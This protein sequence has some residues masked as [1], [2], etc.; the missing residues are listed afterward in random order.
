MSTT[1]CAYPWDLLDDPG[2]TARVTA[3]GADGVVIAAAYHSVR[4]ATPLHP[5]RAVVHATRAAY[6]L[7]LAEEVW[8]SSALR[9]ST[10]TPWAGDE[11]FPR[12]A[13]VARAA[14]LR[15][16]AWL[17]LTHSSHLGSRHPHLTV[18]NAF[19]E[20]YPYALCPSAPEVRDYAR[21]LVEGV[22]RTGNLDGLMIE[23][24]GPLGIGHLGHHE[25]TQGADWTPVAER[26]LSVCF[27]DACEAMLGRET[28]ADR[29]RAE[30]RA[31]VAA[32]LAGHHGTMEDH[33]TGAAAVLA[34]RAAA[35]HDLVSRIRE[36]A[37]PVPRV[38]V[39]GRPDPWATGPFAAVGDDA[40]AFD[41]VVVPGG[42]LTD[43][44]TTAESLRA[45]FPGARLGGYLMALPPATAASVVEQWP[46]V[47]AEL[48]DAYLYHLGLLSAARLEAVGTAVARARELRARMP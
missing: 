4:A 16:E 3:A 14:G 42:L 48:D 35:R 13:G 44:G 40:T 31:G 19:H 47:L 15:V 43:G 41:G 38:V 37:A 46:P 10:A 20:H 33:L 18:R 1:F 6:Y 32:E 7:P 24:C 21:R 30:V 36:A 28:D 22:V 27:C 23:A 17:V 5:R 26:L 39:H 11:A 2:A 9:P 29:L 25:K 8:A 45:T 34:V 12:A